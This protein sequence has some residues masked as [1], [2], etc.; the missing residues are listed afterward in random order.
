MTTTQRYL[1][2][3]GA[4]VALPLALLLGMVL[5]EEKRPDP[6]KH[7]KPHR[8]HL[9]HSA[10]FEEDFA[11]GQDVTRRCL[12]CHEDAAHELMQT[13]HWKWLGPETEIPGRDLKMAI[14]K[15]NLIN[16]FCIGVMGGNWE[17]C[18]K[19]HAGYG[20]KDDSYDFNKEENVDC[21]VCHDWSGAYL[22]GD[23]GEPTEAKALL[24]AAKSVG[25]PRRDNC[26]TCHYYG[27]GGMGVKH[28][29]LDSSLIN[30]GKDID[31]HMGKQGF[32]C[33]DCHKTKDHDIKGVAYSVSATH[34]NGISCADCHTDKPHDDF[35]L[36]KHTDAI[37]CQTCHIP[38]F[39]LAKSTKTEWDWSKAGKTNETEDVHHYLRKKGKF[40][41]EKEIIPEYYWF[42]MTVDRYLLG[43]KI[44]PEA[45]TD[46]NRPR[47]DISDA[48]AKIWPFKVHRGS[49]IYDKEHKYFIPPQTTGDQG[50]WTKYDWDLAL[51][52]GAEKSG[53]EYSGEYDFNQTR[54][55]WPISHMTAEKE[56]ALKCIDCHSP[57]PRMPWTELG[58]SG[59]PIYS[60]NRSPD[61]TEHSK[62]KMT[63]QSLKPVLTL[64][65]DY[66]TNEYDY[67]CQYFGTV[68]AAGHLNQS[69][70]NYDKKETL[71]YPYDVH[72]AR[73][74]NCSD[75]HFEEKAGK[76]HQAVKPD[77]YHLK[78]DPR[79]LNHAATIP[80]NVTNLGS[81]ECAAC[82]DVK[83]T[84]RKL[85]FRDRHMAKVSCQACHIPQMDVPALRVVD[86]TVVDADGANLRHFTAV[87]A[88]PNLS[89]HTLPLNLAR[90]LLAT[91]ADHDGKILPYNVIIEFAWV[92]ERNQPVDPELVAAIFRSDDGDP[93][94]DVMKQFDA[95]RDGA[96]DDQE[97]TLNTKAKHE[98]VRSRLI[99]AGVAKPEIRMDVADFEISHGVKRGKLALAECDS[100]HNSDGRT[101]GPMTIAGTTPT[102]FTRP[103]R[104]GASAVSDALARR[105]GILVYDPRKALK[106]LHIFG[107]TTHLSSVIGA[108]LFL[109]TLAGVS[110]HGLLRFI[111]WRRTR[112]RQPAQASPQPARR[113]MM[114]SAHKRFFHWMLALGMLALILSGV[115]IHFANFMPA[116][117]YGVAVFIHNLTAF[118]LLAHVVV[119][120]LFHLFSGDYQ[121]F[122]PNLKRLPRD[123]L[124]QARY[125]AFGIFTGEP[126][127]FHKSPEHRM[128]PMQQMAYLGLLLGLVPLQIATGV[129]IYLTGHYPELTNRIGGLVHIG[130]LHNVVSWLIISFLVVHLY[131]ITTGERVSS[132][133][134][135]MVT[136]YEEEH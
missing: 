54:M 127:P 34:H 77:V 93:P 106:G 23:A 74:L 50:Y 12:E 107:A 24:T 97:L 53:L 71:A 56:K 4:V 38:K 57:E 70:L 105:A 112:G 95:N 7:V 96:L 39:A 86:R 129:L 132:H 36:N 25:Y 17:S 131:L 75:C 108:L 26:G 135:A 94:L 37:A 63:L 78:W 125:Y 113:V 126:N 117:S 90:P 103:P 43:D 64:P 18:T 81:A 122:L 102:Q 104:D 59:D 51:T 101:A 98:F 136:G 6:W 84:H 41:Y 134:K 85:P 68:F 100:C 69:A 116:V 9:D 60:V 32:Y 28:G 33:I 15:K 91:S 128:N 130:P 55:H 3:S 119:S 35:R 61:M 66:F 30:P 14:G 31:A 88:D 133:L 73:G 44:D 76:R 83:T 123:V 124:V 22:K 16:N 89:D 8:D 40:V 42:N 118:L 49:Q 79:K 47:G 2:L 1:V 111:N 115:K 46:M 13:A 5:T 87:G 10:F 20:W 121:Q 19:C 52:L 110:G 11:S 109:A 80:E 120:F 29:D 67:S 72:A 48:T 82:H 92:D 114:Y 45:V 27:G 58:Y 62:C 99:A 21:L 65:G